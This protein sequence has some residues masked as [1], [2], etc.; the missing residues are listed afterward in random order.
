VED[1]RPFR[2]LRRAGFVARRIRFG[3][4]ETRALESAKCSKTT[5]DDEQLVKASPKNVSLDGVVQDTDGQDGFSL[6]GSFVQSA[7]NHVDELRSH[8]SSKR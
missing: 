4:T 1:L 5:P 7:G 3:V 8:G 2:W 6:G